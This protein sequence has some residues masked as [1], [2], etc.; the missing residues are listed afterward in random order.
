MSET[1]ETLLN[2]E[3]PAPQPRRGRGRPRLTPVPDTSQAADKAASD[4]ATQEAPS[5][6]E[7]PRRRKSA[8]RAHTEAEIEEQRNEVMAASGLLAMMMGAPELAIGPEE[9][10]LIAGRVL[11]FKREFSLE[12]IMGGKMG[13]I[14]G[15][16]GAVAIV[17]VPRFQM[18]RARVARQ[19]EQQ[20]NAHTVDVHGHPV[21]M[22][23]APKV[24]PGQGAPLDATQ[25]VHE[26]YR[27]STAH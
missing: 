11:N 14:A 5:T 10:T 25:A 8:K 16:V 26:H 13:A 6:D 9:A 23:P 17:A 1:A 18:L 22:G 21:G 20:A 2:D 3:P 12:E 15:L 7:K 24:D 27:P 19:R 4:T